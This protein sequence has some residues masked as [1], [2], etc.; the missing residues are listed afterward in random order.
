MPTALQLRFPGRRYHATPWGHHVNEGLVEWPPSP[1]RLLR[2]LLSTGFARLG[3]PAEG[4]PPVA[5]S[6]IERLAAETP[7]FTLPPTTQAHSRHY[8]DAAG[9]KPLVLDT[10]ANVEQGVVEARWQTELPPEERALLALLAENMGYLGR[11]ESWVEARLAAPDA[12]SPEGARCEPVSDGPAG[13]GYET[14]RVLCPVSAADYAAWR[15]RRVVPIVAEHAPAAGRKPTAVQKKKLEAALAPYPPDLIAALC[16]ETAALQSYGWSSPPGAREM[17]YAWR[18]QD[19]GVASRRALVVA[20]GL[21]RFALLALSTESGGSSALPPLHRVFPQGRLLHRAL[22]SVVG[23]QL[24]GDPGLRARL[25]GLGDTGP[26]QDDHGHAHLLHL[27][28]G[29]TSRLDHAL[30]YAPGGLDRSALDALGRLRRTYMKGGAGEIQ[31]AL[32]GWGDATALRALG[33]PF[34][35]RLAAVLGPPGGARAWV[36]ATPYVAP[37]LLKRRGKDSLE[38]LIRAD[39]ARRGWPEVVQIEPLGPGDAR[40]RSMRHYVL[41]D[42]K[43]A[44]PHPAAHALRIVFAEPVEG[45]LCLGYGAHAGLGRFEAVLDWYS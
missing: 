15:A 1:W 27:D 41:H 39:C 37:R 33:P 34:G 24:G 18:R 28:L 14:T 25:L 22:A 8:V 21:T 10:W 38:G 29:G 35:A 19:L 36:S 7:V 12:P 4:P 3:W 17:L 11:A 43:H 44:P 45:P 31:V 23:K 32:S 20:S 6:L 26:L 13:P 30:V 42:D 16:V 40:L 9:K 5:R 2:A